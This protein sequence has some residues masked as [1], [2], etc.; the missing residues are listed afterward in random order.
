MMSEEELDFLGED[1]QAG[2]YDMNINNIHLVAKLMYEEL[3]YETI[4]SLINEL[5]ANIQFGGKYGRKI[6]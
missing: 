1:I 3:N 4:T 6:K 5:E 2:I